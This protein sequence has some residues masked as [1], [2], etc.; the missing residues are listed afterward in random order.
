MKWLVWNWYSLPSSMLTNTNIRCR[1]LVI[2]EFKYSYPVLSERN[3]GTSQYI[4]EHRFNL[5]F[6][7]WHHGDSLDSQSLDH[8]LEDHLKTI[9]HRSDKRAMGMQEDS[10]LTTRKEFWWNDNWLSWQKKP[11]LQPTFYDS[12]YEYVSKCQIPLSVQFWIVTLKVQTLL[13]M[14]LPSLL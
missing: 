5:L 12:G 2:K 3:K 14:D 10:H 4:S 9:Q 11:Q 13:V 6:Y 1:L 8:L 7:L